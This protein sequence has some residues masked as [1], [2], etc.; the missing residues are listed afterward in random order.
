MEKLIKPRTPVPAKIVIS[1]SEGGKTPNPTPIK[2]CL[3]NISK[4]LNAA[5][6]LDSADPLESLSKTKT[7]IITE[8]YSKF[9]Y[10]KYSI[11]NIK[12]ITAIDLNSWIRLGL[13]NIQYKKWIIT[14]PTNAVVDNASSKDIINIKKIYL[15]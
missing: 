13:V 6:N 11:K 12:V 5:L 10:K 14:I 2:G 8:I 15:S 7:S 3:K 1:K 4:A 9:L